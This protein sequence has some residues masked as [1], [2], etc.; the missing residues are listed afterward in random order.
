MGEVGNIA[1]RIL[2][3]PKCLLWKNILKLK[4]LIL[5][6]IC[7]LQCKTNTYEVP[8]QLPGYCALVMYFSNVSLGKLCR[9]GA[10]R[11]LGKFLVDS[12]SIKYSF[13]VADQQFI[14]VSLELIFKESIHKD[15]QFFEKANLGCSNRL[16]VCT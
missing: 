11:M 13:V 1:N 2:H 14:F 5:R 10:C 7:S 9:N 12:L 15:L 6:E 4:F 8:R 3:H 16:V